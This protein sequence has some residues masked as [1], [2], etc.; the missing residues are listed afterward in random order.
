M[1][2]KIL[3]VD[4]EP[5][6]LEGFYRNLSRRFPLELAQ[7]GPQAIQALEEHGPFAVIVSDMRMP[8]MSGLELLEDVR[9]RFPQVIRIMLTGNADQQTAVDAVNRGSVFRFLNK[10]CGPAD[11]ALSIEAGLRQFQLLRA[12]RELLE[13]TLTGAVKVLTEVVSLKEPVRYE[14]ATTARDLS[15]AIARR[16]RLDSLWLL[17]VAALLSP[18]GSLCPRPI[19]ES[20]LQRDPFHPINQEELELGARMIETIPRLEPVARILRYLGKHYDGSGLPADDLQ[21]EALPIESRILFATLAFAAVDRQ[22]RHAGV[23]LE[24]LHRQSGWFDPVVLTALAEEVAPDRLPKGTT[25]VPVISLREGHVLGQDLVL[26]DGFKV[27]TTGTRIGR[28]H[29][30][31]LGD[32]GKLMDLPLAVQVRSLP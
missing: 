11:L 14:L 21:G 3:L 20:V 18:L 15:L 12:E 10:P 9:E 8:G 5:H 7:G 2:D 13:H 29:L 1:S 6:V 30:L 16:L 32:L 24:E 23:A 19:A 22:R 26:S 28:A 17:E 31:M 4:D 25:V 27:F